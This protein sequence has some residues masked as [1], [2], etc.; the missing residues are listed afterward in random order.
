MSSSHLFLDRSEAGRM[1]T[2]LL[3]TRNLEGYTIV[4]VNEGGVELSM[5]LAFA[6]HLPVLPLAVEEFFLCHPQ[7]Q[8]LTMTS[9]GNGRVHTGLACDDGG[10]WGCLSVLDPLEMFEFEYTHVIQ[11][12]MY[13][14]TMALHLGRPVFAPE[15]VLLVIDEIGDGH[16]LLSAIDGL[17]RNGTKQIVIVTPVCERWMNDL[18]DVE[19]ISIMGLTDWSALPENFE[20]FFASIP[21]RPLEMARQIVRTHGFGQGLAAF[22]A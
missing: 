7:H 1:L 22:I 9:L 15:N 21:S 6:R 12:H 13:A 10:D 18:L 4:A 16:G 20:G 3:A 14:R 19:C 17:R 11:P 5:E 2:E 8:Y